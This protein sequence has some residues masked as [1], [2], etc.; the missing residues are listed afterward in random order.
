M[1]VRIDDDEPDEE[2]FAS[3]EHHILIELLQAIWYMIVSHT[4]FICYGCVFLNQVRWS[5]ES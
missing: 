5:I 1:S 4:D 3:K 2:D